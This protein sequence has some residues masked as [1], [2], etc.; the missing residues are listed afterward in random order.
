MTAWLSYM[1]HEWVTLAGAKGVGGLR[2]AAWCTS[3]GCLAT[4][5]GDGELSRMPMRVGDPVAG[6]AG[7]PGYLDVSGWVAYTMLDELTMRNWVSVM[8]GVTVG[9]ELASA[10]AVL[11]MSV[12]SYLDTEVNSSGDKV[13]MAAPDNVCT[14][15][16]AFGPVRL[17]MPV[18]GAGWVRE[19]S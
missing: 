14:K 9:W 17:I 8:T 2:V 11:V 15:V 13:N 7:S 12:C 19:R 10:L 16:S 5:Y 18:D 1:H 3:D 6:P 4:A